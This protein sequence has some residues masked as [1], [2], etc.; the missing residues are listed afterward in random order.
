MSQNSFLTSINVILKPPY[1][2]NYSLYENLSNHAII[3][4]VGGARP[5]DILLYGTLVNTDRDLVIQTR[6]GY[7]GGAFNHQELIRPRL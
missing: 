3:T 1:S 4:L 5:M 6:S 7:M 2:S